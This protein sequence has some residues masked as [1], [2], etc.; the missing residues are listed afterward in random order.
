MKGGFII[1]TGIPFITEDPKH[2]PCT[3]LKNGGNIN[4]RNHIPL[5]HLSNYL[6]SCGISNFALINKNNTHI[7]YYPESLEL[8]PEDTLID[9]IKLNEDMS[10]EYVTKTQIQVHKTH[11]EKKYTTFFQPDKYGNTT[12]FDYDKFIKFSYNIIPRDPNILSLIEKYYIYKTNLIA[13]IYNN[14]FATTPLNNNSTQKK[15]LKTRKIYSKYV[16]LN[17][18]DRGELT[19]VEY[20]KSLNIVSIFTFMN[21]MDLLE[22]LID[23]DEE[24]LDYKHNPTNIEQN[25]QIFKSI[26]SLKFSNASTFLDSLKK[27]YSTKDESLEN[28]LQIILNLDNYKNLVLEPIKQKTLLQT[29]KNLNQ[30]QSEKLPKNINTDTRRNKSTLEISPK[31]F[32]KYYCNLKK[33]HVKTQ[34]QNKLLKEQPVLQTESR[35]K[36]TNANTAA[37]KTSASKSKEQEKTNDTQLEIILKNILFMKTIIFIKHFLNKH[38][39]CS[40]F[41]IDNIVNIYNYL[42]QTYNYKLYNDFKTSFEKPNNIKTAKNKHITES[43]VT[44]QTKK[45]VES[46][47]NN[48]ILVFLEFISMLVDFLYDIHMIREELIFDNIMIDVT[49]IIK[50]LI[51][52]VYINIIID[53][54]SNNN[55]PISLFD[56]AKLLLENTML[57]N[58]EYTVGLTAITPQIY[59]YGNKII[60]QQYVNVKIGEHTFNFMNCGEASLFNFFNHILIDKDTDTI[61]LKNINILKTLYPK[62]IFLDQIY[63]PDV[64]EQIDISKQ[65]K[66]LKGKSNLFATLVSSDGIQNTSLYSESGL[67]NLK[68]DFNNFV[69]IISKL[70]GIEQPTDN[71]GFLKHLLSQLN[72]NDFSYNGYDEIT[73]KNI[74]IIL[75]AKHASFEIESGTS[76]DRLPLTNRIYNFTDYFITTSFFYNYNKIINNTLLFS[77]KY[78]YDFNPEAKNSIE[79]TTLI[80]NLKNSDSLLSLEKYL[81]IAQKIKNIRFLLFVQETTPEIQKNL[82]MI[83]YCVN[84][85][86]LDLT[87]YSMLDNINIIEILPKLKIIILPEFFNGNI[88]PLIKCKELE[89]IVFPRSYKGNIDILSELINLKKIV[90]FNDLLD[91]SLEPLKYCKNLKQI[92]FYGI[93][94]F[95]LSK[96]Q[97]LVDLE[98]LNIKIGS[99]NLFKITNES[100]KKKWVNKIP[101]KQKVN[102]T[103]PLGGLGENLRTL[104]PISRAPQP[105]APAAQVVQPGRRRPLPIFNNGQPPPW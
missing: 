72:I 37:V 68:P 97:S 4:F 92:E 38:D 61:T 8:E 40:N 71:I 19:N 64:I 28:A 102:N 33:M 90:F 7:Y 57:R 34:T 100:G 50:S 76:D 55:L 23:F 5:F 11:Q 104:F 29:V 105:V 24:I 80:I 86:Y 99:K 12:I 27:F 35:L 51:S 78:Y 69:I 88:S 47:N 53:N 59:G 20:Q 70:L 81:E 45:L 30:T 96:L 82:E 41:I 16:I 73:F 91:T 9:I 77:Y 18:N 58:D 46:I 21:N 65:I 25:Q 95:D 2:Q 79:N 14:L 93:R 42:T 48:K 22:K 84:L 31:L 26:K 94:D 49:P 66:I 43:I 67:V 56:H 60:N 1:G 83:K 103:P 36:N 62:N 52:G 39:D 85:Q 15:Y 101:E 74:K 87:Y 32:M 10:L 13:K 44:K 89:E 3:I 75:R 54:Q 17:T 6:N 98:F 63:T